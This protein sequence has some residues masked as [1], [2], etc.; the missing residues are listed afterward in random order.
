[1]SGPVDTDR[2]VRTKDDGGAKAM[3]SLFSRRPHRRSGSG[4][5]GGPAP[6]PALPPTSTLTAF[7]PMPAPALPPS[8]T[9]MR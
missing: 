9:L 3:L 1:M 6:A 2:V 5:A 7:G 4:P 8:T